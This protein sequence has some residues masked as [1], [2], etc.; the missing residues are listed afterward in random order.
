MK[1]IKAEAALNNIR[2]NTMSVWCSTLED[3]PGPN[4]T[5]AGNRIKERFP[6]LQVNR[7]FE[8]FE[9]QS[10]Y[11]MGSCFAR[12]IEAALGR[13]GFDVLS[14]LTPKDAKPEDFA[15]PHG[16]GPSNFLNRYNTASMRAEIERV[17]DVTPMGDEQLTY[18]PPDRLQDLHF[19]NSCDLGD[20]EL[21]TR[22]RRITKTVG[23][24]LRH[25]D[26]VVLTLGLTEAWYD[27]EG[28]GY[29]NSA[30]DLHV[31]RRNK[32][33]FEVRVLGFNENLANLEAMYAA[34]RGANPKANIVLTVSPVPL[35]A[36]FTTQDVV[37]AN[38]N[39]KTTLRAVAAE[40]CANHEDVLYFPSYEIVTYSNPEAAWKGDRRHVQTEMVDFIIGTFRNAH[41]LDRGG[42]QPPLLLTTIRDENVSLH[43][44][45]V[46]GF[47]I[48]GDEVALHPFDEGLGRV[49]EVNF[50]KISTKGLKTFQCGAQM[51]NDHCERVHFGVRI[52]KSGT[53]ELLGEAFVDVGPERAEVLAMD[54]APVA[55]P[56]VDVALFTRMAEPGAS[57]AHAWARFLSPTLIYAD[58]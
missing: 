58:A 43:D 20:L 13:G 51:A 40:F 7:T 38:M 55:D 24:R 3:S 12:E 45:L 37:V 30:L 52:Y 47:E 34:I 35:Q 19:G 23:S 5:Y 39:S 29:L 14:C 11:A 9:G 22:R 26:I 50:G 53:R 31:M 57:S 48:V 56:V 28:E 27:N 6:K 21:V 32:E 1:I 15:S 4:P 41:G 33:R 17:L 2:Q 44:G 10:V 25:A 42:S 49:A 36:T 16:W 8:I 46:E 18:G 54:V